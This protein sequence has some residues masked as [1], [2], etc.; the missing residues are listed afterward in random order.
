[1]ADHWEGTE[2][3]YFA[4]STTTDADGTLRPYTEWE[5]N[6]F[7]GWGGSAVEDNFS[8]GIVYTG[9]ST[10]QLY[11]QILLEDTTGEYYATEMVPLAIDEKIRTISSKTEKGELGYLVYDDHAEVN[12]YQGEDTEIVIPEMIGG[13]PV[14]RINTSVFGKM[15]LFDTHGTYP[16]QNVSLPDTIETIGNDAFFCC[17]KLESINFPKN[18]KE[19]GANAFYYCESLQKAELPDGLTRIGKAAFAY[20]SGMQEITIPK[21][22]EYF[23]EGALMGCKSLEMINVASDN[24]K[25]MVDSGALYSIDGKTLYAWPAAGQT[26]YSVKDGTERIA[27]GAFMSAALIDAVLPEGLKIID[28]YAFYNCRNL[29]PPV[30]PE[31]LEEIGMYAFDIMQKSNPD[32]HDFAEYQI[33][34]GPNVS[35][36]GTGAFGGYIR[37]VISVA[38]DNP[39]FS[40]KDGMLMNKAGDAL[41]E[42]SFNRRNQFIVPDGTMEFSFDMLYF[43]NNY[44][45]SDMDM[46]KHIYIPDSVVRMPETD[47]IIGVENIVFHCNPGSAAEQYALKYGFDVSYLSDPYYEEAEVATAEG[48]MNFYIY[49]DYAQLVHYAGNDTYIEIP[50]EVAG[51]PVKKIGN[52]EYAISRNSKP[53]LS[54]EEYNDSPNIEK[55]IIPEGVEEISAY[56]LSDFSTSHDIEIF[57]PSTLKVIGNTGINI[58]GTL[59]LPEGLESL[60]E[61][62]FTGK[63]EGVFT[64]TPSMKYIDPKAFNGCKGITQFVLEEENEF[65]NVVDGVIYSKDGTELLFYPQEGPETISIPE[66][67]EVIGEYAFFENKNLTE[68]NLPSSLKSI[69]DRAFSRCFALKDVY[70]PEAAESII[71]GYDAFSYCDEL[72]KIELNAVEE[73]GSSAFKNCDN[74]KNVIL[75]EGLLVIGEYAFEETPYADISLPDSLRVIG[76]SA[77]D[78]YK[79]PW[80]DSTDV[81]RIGPNVSEIGYSAFSA[82]GATAF[83][84]DPENQYYESQ[85]GLLMSKGGAKTVSCPSGLEG[86]VFVPEGTLVI[87]DWTFRY[88]GKVTKIHIPSSVVTI[89]SVN[90]EEEFIHGDDGSITG[91]VYNVTIC[92]KPGSYAYKFAQENGIPVIFD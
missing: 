20:C 54:D 87:D 23:G 86:E 7:N 9:D 77:F 80:E 31:S 44:F 4:L 56:A 1:E 90:F 21:T 38:E 5:E 46:V 42:G 48:A 68:V 12:T 58:N 72:T 70:F 61:C 79:G 30:F 33:G 71:I 15:I 47:R 45:S 40:S 16:V 18:L 76:K 27:Y 59:K 43:F 28:N 67:C 39:Y 35:Y 88:A 91:K 25:Y 6:G 41:I 13:K 37:K 51:K 89:G 36:I 83:E 75:K 78:S 73:I 66:G 74:L 55:V 26:T 63:V 53:L 10:W 69:K 52:G 57:L 81:I 2:Y 22:V 60:G 65:Y 17:R 8:F 49:G 64:I 24:S 85:N 62:F 11:A 50:S 92:C 29:N 34:L 3:N 14:T 82:I 32:E 19:I 84:V